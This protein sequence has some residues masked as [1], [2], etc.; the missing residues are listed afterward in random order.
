MD[1]QRPAQG[2]VRD[3]AG[4]EIRSRIFSTNCTVRTKNASK[5][6]Y[7]NHC[8]WFIRFFFS[9]LSSRQHLSYRIRERNWKF[10]V[11]YT[12]FPFNFS[13]TCSSGPSRLL[14]SEFFPF[15]SEGFP[16]R[17]N[18]N[19]PDSLLARDILFSLF[20]FLL[21][22]FYV[23]YPR[24]IRKLEISGIKISSGNITMLSTFFSLSFS[25]SFFSLS[26]RYDHHGR[27][28]K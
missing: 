5:P 19:D 1:L 26:S 28:G 20:L 18:V 16:S 6:D 22:F 12:R 9:F 2:I 3:R 23:K 10:L 24:F 11:T 7:I 14:E 15:V 27:R 17:S 13:R 25:I 21:L 4:C 8:V